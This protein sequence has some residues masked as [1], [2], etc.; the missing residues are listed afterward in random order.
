METRSS[1]NLSSGQVQK[2]EKQI[3]KVFAENCEKKVVRFDDGKKRTYFI[4]KIGSDSFI[5]KVLLDFP[6][7][8]KETI[9]KSVKSILKRKQVDCMISGMFSGDKFIYEKP[10]KK[11]PSKT[12]G[13]R[14]VG[15]KLTVYNKGVFFKKLIDLG[16]S[17]QKDYLEKLDERSENRL[18]RSPVSPK[19]VEE[20]F[21]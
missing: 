6:D 21:D 14:G 1:D 17:E 12:V 15:V 9:S 2:I 18:V 10:S 16:L 20:V 19:V 4:S 7:S 5:L 11:D 13:V 8:E 3:Y